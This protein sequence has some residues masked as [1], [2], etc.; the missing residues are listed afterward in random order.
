M[1]N[2]SEVCGYLSDSEILSSVRTVTSTQSSDEKKE[3]VCTERPR[4]YMSTDTFLMN[5][6]DLSETTVMNFFQV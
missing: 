6:G 3:Q 5:F 4:D 1:D 2:D